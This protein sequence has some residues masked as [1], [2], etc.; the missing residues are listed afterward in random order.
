M[1]RARR[2]EQGIKY[3]S[4]D[5]VADLIL[6]EPKRD[7]FVIIDVRSTD[8]AGGNLPGAVNITTSE[9]RDERSLSRLIH[10]HILPRP[11]LTL[12]ILH[13][14]RSQTRG[15]FAAHLLSQSPLLPPQIEVRV[16]E[17]GF[18]GW[19]RR[20]RDDERRER[21]FEG[22]LERQEGSA[23]EGGEWVD[24][25]QANEGEDGEAEDSRELRR[26]LGR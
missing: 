16:M 23:R 17:G 14:M 13:C 19:W 3:I 25:V 7:D 11:S 12:L 20:F 18:A 1:P 4:P 2:D 15:P 8:F 6:A 10:T 21:L 22:L 9:F 24:V 5:Q 26:E